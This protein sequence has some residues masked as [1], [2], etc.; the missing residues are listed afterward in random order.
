MT[1]SCPKS[2]GNLSPC[3]KIKNFFSRQNM[4]LPNPTYHVHGTA[5]MTNFMPMTLSTTMMAA[6]IMLTF[7]IRYKSSKTTYDLYM[8]WWSWTTYGLNFFF[9]WGGDHTQSDLYASIYGINSEK[10]GAKVQG[11][12][13]AVYTVL[14]DKNNRCSQLEAMFSL[15]D[16]QNL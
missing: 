10:S 6:S 4:Q 14:D 3:H 13:T 8:G 1:K 11:F 5:E 16:N 9:F 15:I 12:T 2:W 7:C